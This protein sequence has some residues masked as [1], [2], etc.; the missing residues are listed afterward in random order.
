VT[1]FIGELDCATNRLEYVSAGHNPAFLID[2]TGDV[3]RLD[4]TGAPLG[5]I[6]GARY[7]TGEVTMPAGGLLCVYS[8]GVTEA[9]AGEEFYDEERL[10]ESLAR[11]RQSPLDDVATGVLDDVQAFLGEGSPGDD[12]TLLLL[13]RAAG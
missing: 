2:A 10:I 7:E 13:R 4:S 5:L 8:D 1:L 9:M 12:V 11:R 6:E 3:A